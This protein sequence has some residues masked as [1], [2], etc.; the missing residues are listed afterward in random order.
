MKR[1]RRPDS[2]FGISSELPVGRAKA[3]NLRYS[4]PSI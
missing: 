2:R 4:I 1:Q 3:R